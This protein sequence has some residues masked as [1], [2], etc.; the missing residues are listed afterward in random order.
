M[1]ATT[2]GRLASHVP[3]PALSRWGVH[4]QPFEAVCQV[5]LTGEAR[6]FVLGR[7]LLKYFPLL[8]A[9]RRDTV[10]PF[11]R[12]ED[13]AGRAIA[14]SPALRVDPVDAF[15]DRTQHQTLTASHGNGATG[16]FLHETGR[17]SC[18]GRVC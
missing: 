8:L 5:D 11:R 16:A 6:S 12:D 17:A 9:G 4:D 18:R 7:D 1:L 15:P 2:S 3:L 13:V 14:G 10:Q